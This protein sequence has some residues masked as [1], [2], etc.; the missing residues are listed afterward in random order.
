M[1][2]LPGTEAPDF[3]FHAHMPDH[4]SIFCHGV[5][6]FTCS[7]FPSSDQP[8]VFMSSAGQTTSSSTSNSQ[9]IIHALA[10]YTKITGIDLSMHS[11]AAKLGLSDSPQYILQLFQEREKA[12]KEYRDGDQRLINC[13][14]SIVSVLQAFSRILNEVVGSLVSERTH[15]LL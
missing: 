14:G 5:P 6:P 8:V 12:I 15:A 7:H 4:P 3:T 10:D 13:L 2:A 9:L 11:F 1:P